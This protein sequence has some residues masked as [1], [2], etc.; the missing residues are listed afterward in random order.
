MLYITGDTHGDYA[1]FNTKELRSL[2]A[3]DTLII[4]GDFGFIWDGEKKK[5]RY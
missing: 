3:D 4:C 2:G 5:N 1:R